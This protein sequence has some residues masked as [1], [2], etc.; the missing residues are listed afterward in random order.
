MS[1]CPICES[2]RIV[3]V[4]QLGAAGLL[5]HMWLS[6]GAGRQPSAEGSPREVSGP[7]DHLL[8]GVTRPGIP[9]TD[10]QLPSPRAHDGP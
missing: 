6:L 5:H 9:L 4:V 10:S 3:V 7:E 1:R 8:G 2:V